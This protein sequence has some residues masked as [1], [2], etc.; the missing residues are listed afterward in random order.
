MYTLSNRG[1]SSVLSIRDL[2]GRVNCGGWWARV[3]ATA[4][5]N[6]SEGLEEISVERTSLIRYFPLSD[7]P[8]PT[9]IDLLKNAIAIEVRI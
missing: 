2:R 3:P 1:I 5:L 7:F 9:L 8:V 6:D 4:T